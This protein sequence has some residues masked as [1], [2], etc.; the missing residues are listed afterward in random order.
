MRWLTKTFA[1]MHAMVAKKVPFAA[2]FKTNKMRGPDRCDKGA[3]N[4]N[5][6]GNA[7]ERLYNGGG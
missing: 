1:T 7:K 6:D 3:A 2:Q 4:K 5:D